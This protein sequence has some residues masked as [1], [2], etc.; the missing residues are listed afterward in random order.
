MRKIACDGCGLEAEFASGHDIRR[1]S[2]HDGETELSGD[3]C[4]TC[5]APIREVFPSGRV[6]LTIPEWV[7]HPTREWNAVEQ[8]FEEVEFEGK[9]MQD[10][11][12]E[13]LAAAK[14]LTP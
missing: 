9:S 8:R 11:A 13:R 12:A 2:F 1:S 5:R 14:R 4:G 6:E 7:P 3:L 10:L